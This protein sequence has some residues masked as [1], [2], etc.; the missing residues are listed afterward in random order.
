MNKINQSRIDE[1][2]NDYKDKQEHKPNEELNQQDK[3]FN[4]LLEVINGLVQL[5]DRQRENFIQK[6]KEKSMNPNLPQYHGRINEDVSEWFFTLEQNFNACDIDD[7]RKVSL[8]HQ[9]LSAAAEYRAINAFNLTYK[10]FK[11]AMVKKFQSP[12]YQ[13]DLR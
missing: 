4:Y 3:K 8:A 11:E 12:N 2:Y 6:P 10:Q 9:Y 1:D 13:T 7:K 5:Q